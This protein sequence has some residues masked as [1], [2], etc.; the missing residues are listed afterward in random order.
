MR[1]TQA[2]GVLP[3]IIVLDHATKSVVLAIRGSASTADWVTDFMGVPEDAG[4]WISDQFR[5]VCLPR[6][7]PRQVSLLP[8]ALSVSP[9]LFCP[10]PFALCLLLSSFLPDFCDHPFALFFRLLLSRFPFVLSFFVSS[11]RP[12]WRKSRL[13]R[14]RTDTYLACPLT[15]AVPCQS[16]TS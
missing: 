8:F 3:Y 6:Q 10:V 14:W 4:G 11:I 7:T 1:G 16:V 12:F 15:D 9:C 2:L 5:K 13:P